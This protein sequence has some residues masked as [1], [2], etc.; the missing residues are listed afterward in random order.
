MTAMH[1][2]CRELTQEL[3]RMKKKAKMRRK[4]TSQV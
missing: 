4:R 2:T 3:T 1:T